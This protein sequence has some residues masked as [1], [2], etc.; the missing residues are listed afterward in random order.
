[1]PFSNNFNPERY[2]GYDGTDVILKIIN[3]AKAVLNKVTG[4]FYLVHSGLADP[5]KVRDTLSING[6]S[7]K[8]IATVEKEIKP[9]DLNSLT[10]GL[11]DYILKLYRQ[12][13]AEL[14]E[15]QGRFFCPVWFYH[16]MIKQ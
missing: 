6:F 10:D 2:G 4:R 7:W 3:E 5:Q 15:K 13:I 8:I 1:M 11:Y 9:A 14:T 12:G 16:G